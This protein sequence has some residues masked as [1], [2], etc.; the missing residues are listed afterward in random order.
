MSSSEASIEPTPGAQA[1]AT[2]RRFA[3]RRLATQPCEFCSEGLAAE[4]RHVLEVATRKI[5]CACTP[6]ALRF[7][8]VAGKWK[9]IPRDARR[10]PDF[11]MSDMQWDALALP[12]NLVFIFHSTPKAE[13]LALYPSPAG[14][15]ESLLPVAQWHSL[16]SDNPVLAQMQTDVEALLINR[17]KPAP[18]YYLA[19]LD[20]C[21]E[22][23][24]TIRVHW[25]G[26]A[27]GEQVWKEIEKFFDTLREGAVESVITPHH[28]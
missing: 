2:L 1:I 12:I 28:A 15:T 5:V 22:L 3:Q 24:G 25:R 9:L 8:S 4:H 21:F 16:V 13:V 17:L 20:R 11:R 6:C 27:G 10:L 26:L 19:P 18:E 7:E 14:A 23:V